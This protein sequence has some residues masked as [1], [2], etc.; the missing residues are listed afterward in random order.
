VAVSH[1]RRW[2]IAI[3]SGAAVFAWAIWPSGGQVE[4]NECAPRSYAASVSAWIF[5]ETFWRAQLDDV[6]RMA[7]D[8]EGW[9]ARRAAAKKRSDEIVEAARAQLEEIRAKHRTPVPTL[10]LR[11]RSTCGDLP[12]ASTPSAWIG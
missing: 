2:L 7:V 3:A 4:T 5:G 8:A 1:H 10:R 9:D 12:T 6:S 11:G